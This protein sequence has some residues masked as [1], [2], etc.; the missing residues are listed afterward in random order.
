M[1][2]RARRSFLAF[3]IAAAGG[4]AGWRWLQS[5]ADA[6]G[7]HAPLRA[8]HEFNARLS[9]AYFS[10]ARLAPTFA[11]ELAREPRVNGGEGLQRRRGSA[12]AARVCPKTSTRP[13]GG[14]K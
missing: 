13:P 7:I 2:R 5:S 9:Q 4:V 8:A 1:T 11:R 6:E 10:P 14:C 12:T 3:G